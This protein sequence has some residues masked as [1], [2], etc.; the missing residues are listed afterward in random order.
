MPLPVDHH[1]RR[2]VVLRQRLL[3]LAI[4]PAAIGL[5]LL[6]PLA[7]SAGLAS[8][9]SLLG[10]NNLLDQEKANSVFSINKQNENSITRDPVTGALIAGAN[11]EIGE[12][13]CPGTS[14]PLASPCP[15]VKGVGVSGFYTSTNNGKTWTGG[16][17]AGTAGRSSG[18]DPS[19]DNGPRLC[20]NGAF[21]YTCGAVIYYGNLEDP[22]DSDLHFSEG[23]AVAHSFDDGATWT[24]SDVNIV[25][26]AQFD[27]HEWVAVDKSP[28]SPHFG[29]V[30]AFWAVFC[31]NC[32]GN[33]NV[34][35]FVAHSDDQGNIWSAP[36]EVSQGGTNN[37]GQ[38]FRETGQMAVS[39]NG[40]VEAFWSE[41]EDSTHTQTL[42]VVA[43]STDGGNT[44]SAPI[45][46]A[47]VTD[48]PLTGTPFDVV[49]LFNRVPG[50]SARVDCF[51]HPATD[52]SS[53]N[54]YVVW[55]DFSGGNGH[56]DVRAAVSPDGKNWKDL[57]VI[58]S[59]AG[60]NAFFPAVS[61]SPSGLVSV[62]F[63]ALTAPPNDNLFQT[64]VQTYDVYYVERAATATGF[65][66]PLKISTAASNPDGSSYNN[67]M[68]QFL[69]DYIGIVDGPSSAY[70][71]WTDSR[72]ASQCTAVDAYRAQVYAGSKTAVAPNPDKACAASFGNTDSMEAAVNY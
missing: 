24:S 48:Y 9:P 52:P 3:S 66:T 16:V 11:D 70:V 64:G 10:G 40:T 30:Y 62:A 25:S 68:E 42:Q 56:G 46:I 2:E 65:T 36:V 15:F 23:M 35:L 26:N 61:V 12:G 51:P 28:A 71:D 6:Q 37:S 59:V 4:L 33:G 55:C 43:T 54:V 57:G 38:G 32:A 21:S 39:S 7:T 44:F 27:D 72:N 17:L 14:T 45:T 69:G 8:G 41:D 22:V 13:P 67:L 19:L 5:A 50:M 63:D 49:D 53:T 31:A 60:S 29:R 58:A 34:K 1:A 20:A 47:P 18:G